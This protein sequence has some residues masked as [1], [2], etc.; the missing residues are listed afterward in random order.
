[1]PKRSR[2][3]VVRSPARVVA[4]TSVNAGRSSVTVRAPAPWP[5][6]IGSWR[7]SIAGYSVS[8]I[9]RFRRW[10]S[11]MKNTD[12]GSS[13][14]RKAA[15]S[16]LRSS[17]GPAVCTIGTSSSAA[18]MWASEV[19]PSPGGPASSTWSRA[20]PRRLAASMKTS[21][22]AVTCCWLTKSQSV[23]GRSERSSSSSG[24]ATWMSAMDAGAGGLEP[25]SSK[26]G[27]REMLTGSCSLPGLAQGRADQ[28]L[29]RIAVDPVE[30]LVGLGERVAEV[31]QAIAREG[32]LALLALRSF[33]HR[34]LELSRDLLAQL[35]DDPLGRALADAGNRLEA[36]GVACG[37]RPEELARRPAREDRDR[38]LRAHAGDGREAEEQ[39]AFLLGGEA[40]QRDR[41]VAQDEVRVQGRLL[42]PGRDG[43]QGLGGHGEPV[44]DAGGVDDHMVG[45]AHQH[46]SCDRGDQVAAPPARCPSGAAR[47]RDTGAKA[48]AG[49]V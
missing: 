32:V 37:D 3:G 26:F 41:V 11:S 45:T 27:S 19:F 21:S 31:H 36:L 14:V 24:P 10:I 40:I 25:G 44:A 43:L 15:M 38:D 12:P 9:A 16:A 5:R 30:E 20:S 47:S 17:A 34:L 1:M 7:S 4:P 18:T 23:C 33:R 39:V 28:D 49:R 42:A 8:S 13:A 22:W 6:T 29:G 2:S 48:W 35:D 46:L